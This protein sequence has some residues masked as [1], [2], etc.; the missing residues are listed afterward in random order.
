MNLLGVS[1]H[2]CIGFEVEDDEVETQER[3]VLL[4]K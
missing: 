2:T 4:S 1:K 3:N